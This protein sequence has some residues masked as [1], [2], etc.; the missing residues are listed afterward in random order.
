MDSLKQPSENQTM[1]INE[2]NVGVVKNKNMLDFGSGSRNNE[3]VDMK[4]VFGCQVDCCG[5]DLRVAK[6]YHQKHR[7]CEVHTKA[8]VVLVGGLPRRFCQKCSRFH[9]VS[10][11]DDAKRSCRRGLARHNE[12]RRK[13]HEE[14]KVSLLCEGSKSKHHSSSPGQSVHVGERA[15]SLV[16]LQG[17]RGFTDLLINCLLSSVTQSP[18]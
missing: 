13:Q 14:A 11:F 1:I 2:N 7:V 17:N 16:A 10:E 8:P 15:R 9:E 18:S 4:G 3:T 6:Q 5:D 12:V